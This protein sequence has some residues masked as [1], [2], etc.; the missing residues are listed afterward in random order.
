M[1]CDSNFKFENFPNGLAVIGL[2]GFHDPIIQ[3]PYRKSGHGRGGGLVIYVNN[4]F[5]DSESF[6]IMKFNNI[7]TESSSTGS[8]P[9]GEFLFLK[10]C[11]KMQPGVTKTF[12]IG[13]IYRSRSPSAKN[14]KFVE[15]LDAHLS[16]LNRHKTKLLLKIEFGFTLLTSN[17]SC[18]CTV[19]RP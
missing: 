19:K 1:F 11:V 14:D 5:C 16:Q 10:I 4:Q 12:I 9:P 15:L 13:N 3:D 2:D 18:W 6:S 17:N 7:S 8:N